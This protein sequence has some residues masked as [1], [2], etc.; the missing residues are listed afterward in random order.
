MCYTESVEERFDCGGAWRAHI[1]TS[2]PP[3]ARA[4]REEVFVREQGFVNEFDDID[5]RAVHVVLYC[6]GEPAG[7]CRVFAEGGRAHIG[8]VAVRRALRGQGAGGMLLAAAE[9]AAREMGFAAA[10]LAAQVR[11][12]GFYEKVGYTACG[13]PFDE[14]GCP[15]IL[16]QK[17][18]V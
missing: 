5:E 12:R 13:A 2:L 6:G 4:I 10:A 16:L 15:H 17:R 8:R 7:T 9:E 11:A 1:S 3:E 18:L 14:E